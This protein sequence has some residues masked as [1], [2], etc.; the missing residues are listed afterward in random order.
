MIDGFSG[1][2]L[3]GAGVVAVLLFLMV[4][5]LRGWFVTKREAESY[6]RRAEAAEANEAQLL[7]Q[8]AELME[9]ARLGR[10][11]FEALHRGAGEGKT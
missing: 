1:E 10:A 7:R 2:F 5:F 6:L 9:M 4:A 8:N 11:T 3:N